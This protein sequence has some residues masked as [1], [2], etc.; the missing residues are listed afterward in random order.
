MDTSWRDDQTEEKATDCQ[1][2]ETSC[3]CGNIKTVI[4]EKMHKFAASVGEKA[5]SQDAPHAVAQYGR[6]AA[7]VLDETADYIQQFDY[8]QADA[9]VRGYIRR[10]PGPSLL[11]AGFTGLIIGAIFRSR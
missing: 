9:K 3:A 4:A 2:S 6:Q 10:N 11:I 1:S 8:E 7:E 5:A